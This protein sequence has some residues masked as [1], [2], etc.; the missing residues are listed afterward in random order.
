MPKLFRGANTINPTASVPTRR[1]V[2]TMLT[3]EDYRN[4]T[5]SLLFCVL[6]AYAKFDSSETTVDRLEVKFFQAEA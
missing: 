1:V 6:V 2:S 3:R 4:I 5:G